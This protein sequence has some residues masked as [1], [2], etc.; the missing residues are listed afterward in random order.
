MASSSTLDLPSINHVISVRLERDNYPTWLAQI[1][2]V[3]RSRRL[4]SY[5]DGSCPSPSPTIS[6]PKAKESESS[7]P[8]LISN[9][10]YED[11][12]QKG[13]LVLSLINGSLHHKVLATVATKTTARDTWLALETRFALRIKI[14]FFSFVAICFAR[15]VM[16]LPSLIF[17][18]VFTLLQITWHWQVLPFMNLIF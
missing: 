14:V 8:S 6:D 1:V 16:I 11:W 9:P 12:I 7:P 15:L 3:L 10:D 5:V 18:I 17:W 2:P 4:L 13:Q